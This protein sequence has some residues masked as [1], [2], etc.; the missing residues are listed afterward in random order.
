MINAMGAWQMNKAHTYSYAVI[1]YM[2]AYLKAH[3]PIE[4]AAANMRNAKDEDQA[5]E[6]LREMVKEGIEYIPFDLQLSKANWSVHEGKLIGGF[7]NLKGIGESKAAK[8]IAARDADKLTAKQRADI[9]KAENFFSDIFPFKTNYGEMYS[10]PQKHGING[11]ILCIEELNGSQKGSCVFIGELIKKS[12]RNANEEMLIKKRN[13][14]KETGP[15]D[16]VD[17]RLRDD[18]GMIGAR[19]GRFDFEQIGRE[20]L[21]RVPE[22]AHLLVRARFVH[23][24][25]F[26]FIT[27]WKW[28]NKPAEKQE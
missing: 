24:I 17:V 18:T 25:R 8:L 10:N 4:F 2:T 20:L 14:K 26:G 19:V 28:L 15:L 9:E 13:G 27:K 12:A 11:D 22:G 6:L 1:S 23:G 5:L 3:H 21:E 16:F 7:M